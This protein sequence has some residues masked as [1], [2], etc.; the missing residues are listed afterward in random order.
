MKYIYFAAILFLFGCSDV[1]KQIDKASETSRKSDTIL[2]EFNKIDQTLSN[3]KKKID[4]ALPTREQEDSL[5]KVPRK[6]KAKFDSL[7]R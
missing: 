7:I 4:D 2:K 1:Q 6:L 3:A 5:L